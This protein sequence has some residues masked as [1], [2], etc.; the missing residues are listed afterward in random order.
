MDSVYERNI[1]G[2]R[3][4]N[5]ACS[6]ATHFQDGEILRH[7]SIGDYEGSEQQK[8]TFLNLSSGSLPPIQKKK[9]QRMF[10]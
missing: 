9:L 1:W 4:G 10:L 2:F 3:K 7:C 5:L 8:D 6:M